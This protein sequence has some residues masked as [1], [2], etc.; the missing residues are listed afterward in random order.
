MDQSLI[1]K[2]I[3][4]TGDGSSTLFVPELNEHY[5]SSKGAIT[6]SSV[7]FI[8]NGFQ[9]VC[10]SINELKVLEVGFGTGLNA[11]LS[12]IES[13]K[14]EA[15]VFYTAVEPFPVED[16][17]LQKLYFER[18]ISDFPQDIFKKMHSQENN[19]FGALSSNFFF[20]KHFVKIEE[21]PT[22]KGQFDLIYFDAFSP[23][24]QPELWT[25]AI[26]KKLFHTLTKSGVLVTYSVKGEVRS[27]LKKAGFIVEKLEGP[28]GKRHVLRAI[29]L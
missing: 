26:F 7:V 27:A 8:R 1:F 6:E 13:Q 16:V 23:T 14:T 20:K 25:D 18:C 12:F 22:G 3:I 24:V 21:F 10:R 5:H 19:E 11:I 28:P 2:S 17:L 29:K 9:W 4:T 15:K